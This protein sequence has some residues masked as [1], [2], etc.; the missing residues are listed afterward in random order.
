MAAPAF[1]SDHLSCASEPVKPAAG[2]LGASDARRSA[3]N[4]TIRSPLHPSGRSQKVRYASDD[5]D[6]HHDPART[7]VLAGSCRVGSSLRGL[8]Q[9]SVYKRHYS[10]SNRGPFVRCRFTPD[11]LLSAQK[12]VS[13]LRPAPNT[14]KTVTVSSLKVNATVSRR[15]NP[16]ILTPGRTSERSKERR[17]LLLIPGGPRVDPE[18]L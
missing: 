9:L 3:F 6:H 16:T 4:A 1:D 15:S 17:R 10:G 13:Q 8:R 2:P 14:R 18:G 7:L 5:P 12:L 11:A